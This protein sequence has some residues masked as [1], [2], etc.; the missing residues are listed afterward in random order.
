MTKLT[1]NPF[2]FGNPVRGDHYFPRQELTNT[3]RQF[4]SN[5]INVV[6][7]GPRRF[8][9]TSF[10]LDLFEHLEREGTSCILVDIFNV[11]SHR[12]FL[13]QFLRALKKK[14]GFKNRLTNWWNKLGRY[15]PHFNLDIDQNTG[16]I[17]TSL[18]FSLGQLDVEEG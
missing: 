13:H 4:L 3:V 14:H 10:V 17:N 1:E 7:M 5:H 16:I 15:T 8:G 2:K 18:G 9:K 6:L 12:D 11:T